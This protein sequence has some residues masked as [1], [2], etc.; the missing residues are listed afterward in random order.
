MNASVQTLPIRGCSLSSPSLAPSLHP[1]RPHGCSLLS[2]WTG[3]IRTNALLC[4]RGRSKKN[5][6]LKMVFGSCCLLEKREKK[7]RFLVFNPQDPK[8]PEL[9]R[10]AVRRRRFFWP[11]SSSHSS[12]FYSSLGWLTSKVPKP[13]FPF[14]LRFIDVDGF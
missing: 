12:K 3:C 8:I 11:S 6:N 4:T 9:R 2:A 10:E 7:S 13:F 5:K 14:I 1:S